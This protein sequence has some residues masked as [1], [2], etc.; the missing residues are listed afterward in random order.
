MENEKINTPQAYITAIERELKELEGQRPSA[1]NLIRI[2]ELQNRF[3]RFQ[4]ECLAAFVR[5]RDRM[6]ELISPDWMGS[7][8]T[9]MDAALTADDSSLREDAKK[10]FIRKLGITSDEHRDMVITLLDCYYWAYSDG[11][12]LYRKLHEKFDDLR[13]K[14]D[15][16]TSAFMDVTDEW[17]GHQLNGDDEEEG[18]NGGYWAMV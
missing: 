11:I 2:I 4:S 1:R 12:H 14:H 6:D 5:Q 7:F 17:F 9:A 10:A 15:E 18:D 3:I 13:K 16:L 8:S